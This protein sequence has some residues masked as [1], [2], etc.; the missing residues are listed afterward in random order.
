MKGHCKYF[1]G[2]SKGCAVGIDIRKFVGGPDLG[3]CTR[4]PCLKKNNVTCSDYTDY[5]DAELATIEQEFKQMED[6]FIRVGP[7]VANIKEKHKGEN[8][9]GTVECPVCK[10]KLHLKHTGYNSH[11]WGKCETENCLSWME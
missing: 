8:W 6:R 10:G 2:I 1:N 9:S 5:T 7:I 4:M 3:W 11:V